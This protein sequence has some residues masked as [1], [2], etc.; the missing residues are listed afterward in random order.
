MNEDLFIYKLQCIMD[1]PKNKI[2]EK[3]ILLCK[4][5]VEDHVDGYMGE[6]YIKSLLKIAI[7]IKK[8]I[9]NNYL[10]EYIIK[11]GGV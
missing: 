1:I 4:A 3:I 8:N 9:I 7:H 6:E 2:K 10:D 11:F 5:M